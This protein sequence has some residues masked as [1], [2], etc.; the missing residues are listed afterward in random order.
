MLHIRSCGWYKSFNITFYPKSTFFG[1]EFILFVNESTFGITA[2]L[3][4]IK[5]ARVCPPPVPML[6]SWICFL[7][8]HTLHILLYNLN[9]HI[10]ILWYTFCHSKLSKGM[11]I[12]CTLFYRNTTWLYQCLKIGTKNRGKTEN[13][14]LIM[15]VTYIILQLIQK[16]MTI[17]PASSLYPSQLLL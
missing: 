2:R 3:N 15:Q 5:I 1:S 4:W 9:V 14:K 13:I 8:L 17:F 7:L 12:I 10:C 16:L 11:Q 6:F